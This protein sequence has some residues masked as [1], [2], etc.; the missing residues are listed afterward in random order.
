MSHI[1]YI[2]NTQAPKIMSPEEL[3][4]LAGENFAQFTID[5]D[6]EEFDEIIQMPLDRFNF[7]ILGQENI[8]G[9]GFE[10][11]YSKENNTYLVRAFT[12]STEADWLSAFLFIKKL[13][14]FLN[15]NVTDEEGEVYK[16]D[17]ITYN[18][19]D[20]IA[21]GVKC[22]EKNPEKHFIFGVHRPICLSE[23]IISKLLSA[24]DKAKTFS[25]FVE[26]Q[27]QHEDVHIAKQSFFRR[28]DN[29]TK[30]SNDDRV[31][32]MYTLTQTVPTVLPYEFPPFIDPTKSDLSEED[33]KLWRICFLSYDENRPE[34]DR[35][36]IIGEMDYKTFVEQLPLEKIQKLD[37]H[38]M[39][40]QFNSREELIP[41]LEK[42]NFLGKTESLF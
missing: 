24:Q 3:L 1:F 22:F 40:F 4:N 36:D 29:K 42:E 28:N 19:R 11:A 2:K 20:N 18:Y 8:S 37:G 34:D 39:R 17:N 41:F 21:F 35:F 25:D 27:L 16:A 31:V 7:M 9:R 6:D 38:Y 14:T 33:I 26:A 10:C 32:C 30:D 12:P 13:A 23:E 15:T 5:E